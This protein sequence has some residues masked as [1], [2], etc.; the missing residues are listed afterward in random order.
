MLAATPYAKCDVGCLFV[1]I[2]CLALLL[3][4]S[5]DTVVHS[6]PHLLYCEGL[7]LLLFY[8]HLQNKESHVSR[9]V[10]VLHGC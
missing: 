9:T 3:Q 10:Q 6:H 2:S 4:K 8:Q 5:M 1:G 7:G